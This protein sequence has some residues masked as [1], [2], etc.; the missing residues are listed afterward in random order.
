MTVKPNIAIDGPAGS[1]KSTVAGLVADKLNY[2]YIDTGA[3]YR[4]MTLKVL[5]LSLDLGDPAVVAELTSST[6]VE[7]LKNSDNTL[8]VLLDDEDVTQ[9]IRSPEVSQN[10]SQVAA[11]PAIRKHLVKLQQA[12]AE[13]G[14][15]VMEGRDIGTVVLPNAGVKVFLTASSDERA[16]RRRAELVAKGYHISQ[17]D[18]RREIEERDAIDSGRETDPLVQATD[19]YAIDCS[20]LSANEVAQLIIDRAGE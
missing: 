3:M 8:R 5:R 6:R 14:G 11:V 9:E 12:M 10:V 15:V 2:L 17:E 19:A 18:M 16:K 7:L 13:E 1:G 4:A 20:V